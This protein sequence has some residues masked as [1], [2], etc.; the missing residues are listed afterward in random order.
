M[1]RSPYTPGPGDVPAVI[2]GR[3]EELTAI[4][5]RLGGVALFGQSAGSPL[6][7]AALRGL[8]KTVLLRDAEDTARSKGFVTAWATGEPGRPLLFDLA[9]SLVRSARELGAS[10][11][12]RLLEWA[13]SVRAIN[14]AA[15]ADLAPHARVIEAVDRGAFVDLVSEL[16]ELVRDE[17]L[18][19]IAVLVDE[20]QEA[21]QSDLRGLA[22]AAQDFSGTNQPVA[23]FMGGL[24]TLPER[25]SSVA[26]FAERFAFR[27]LGPLEPEDARLALVKPAE[28]E[29]VDWEPEAEQLVL[30]ASSGFPYLVQLY[31]DTAWRRTAPDAAGRVITEDAARSG[32]AAGRLILEQGLFRARWRRASDAEREVLVALAKR[33]GDAPALTREVAAAIGKTPQAMSMARAALIEKGIVFAPR[34]GRLQ[35]TMPGFARY[36]ASA[37]TDE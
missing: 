16:A 37:S 11:S 22:Y 24:P 4:R 14:G 13:E 26:S 18:A 27:G 9:A 20:L 34:H 23:M 31:G 29:G 21:P 6:V 28:S 33:G 25:L 36:V 17:G 32:I 7:F 3:D 35:F 5:E 1:I 15:G 10:R 19:G 30:A 2:A 12:Q 8:G